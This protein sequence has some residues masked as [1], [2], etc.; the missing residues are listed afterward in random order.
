[1]LNQVLGIHKVLAVI[2]MASSLTLIRIGGEVFS[3]RRFCPFHSPDL[4]KYQVL[5]NEP[6]CIFP[7]MNH[8]LNYCDLDFV[9]CRICCKK[10]RKPKNPTEQQSQAHG[11]VL[12]SLEF[13][14]HCH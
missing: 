3:D 4:I 9:I 11:I 2:T 13:R 12:L 6:S 14:T 10:P 8:T 5:I 1:M 7:F